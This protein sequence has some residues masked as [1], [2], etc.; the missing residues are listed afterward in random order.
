M[1]YNVFMLVCAYSYAQ[2]YMYRHVCVYMYA[3]IC[4]R[5][6]VISNYHFCF[7]ILFFKRLG[8]ITFYSFICSPLF[9]M[10]FFY[11][12]SGR[13]VVKMTFVYYLAGFNANK[14]S[15]CSWIWFSWEIV[16]FPSNRFAVIEKIRLVQG[17]V[18]IVRW[19]IY[20]ALFASAIVI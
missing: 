17:Q 4:K 18:N 12:L 6:W 2:I 20:S 15:T 11:H 7:P 19:D 3:Q 8:I 5:S 16:F 14:S 9:A 13:Y 10:I 1:L